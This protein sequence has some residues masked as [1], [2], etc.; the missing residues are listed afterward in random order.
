MLSLALHIAWFEAWVRP[1]LDASEAYRRGRAQQ[2]RRVRL[3]R[4]GIPDH[5]ARQSLRLV[6]Q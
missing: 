6:S 1:S 3:L 2:E 4:R 5:L